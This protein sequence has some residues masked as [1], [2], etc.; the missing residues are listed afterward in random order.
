MIRPYT[1]DE[2]RLQLRLSL[3]SSCPALICYWSFQLVAQKKIR[4]AGIT[5]VK[6]LN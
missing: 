3:L 5:I 2:F 1:S 6:H 4:Q